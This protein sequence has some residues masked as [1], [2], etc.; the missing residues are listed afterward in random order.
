MCDILLRSSSCFCN[1]SY[2]SCCSEQRASV[3][4]PPKTT[5]QLALKTCM[6]RRRTPVHTYTLTNTIKQ[7][8]QM[9]PVWD[10][11]IKTVSNSQSLLVWSTCRANSWEHRRANTAPNTHTLTHTRLPQLYLCCCR[12]CAEESANR[13][14]LQRGG[15]KQT[16]N[17]AMGVGLHQTC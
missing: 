13:C 16:T 15:G 10:D 6:T 17:V 1:D 7:V 8:S 3:G 9:K 14:P 5:E 12:D 2:S 4:G 11:L